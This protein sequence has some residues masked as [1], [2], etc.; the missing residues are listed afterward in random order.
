MKLLE[1]LKLRQRYRQDDPDRFVVRRE[2]GFFVAAS[3]GHEIDLA[4]DHVAANLRR[5]GQI[6]LDDRPVLRLREKLRGAA[7]IGR[8]VTAKSEGGATQLL[9]KGGRHGADSEMKRD[10]CPVGSGRGVV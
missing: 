2:R 4:T 5:L 8:V 10:T 9:G 1:Q 7:E 3:P 6:P